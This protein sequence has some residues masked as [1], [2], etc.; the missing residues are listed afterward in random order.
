M[1]LAR[2]T[3]WQ[4][5]IGGKSTSRRGR[6]V[7]RRIALAG[8]LLMGLLGAL[9]P[10]APA[11]AS[12]AIWLH[13]QQATFMKVTNESVSM[14]T[15]RDHAYILWLEEDASHTYDW[16]YYTTNASGA[17]KTRLLSKA[18]PPGSVTDQYRA[19]IAVDPTLK[20]LYAVWPI[21][22]AHGGALDLYTSDDE[23]A[24]WKWKRHLDGR[25]DQAI[26]DEYHYPSVIQARDGA[27]HVTYSYFVKE[28]K[29]IKH[30]RF[31]EDWIKAGD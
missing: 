9:V 4:P 20:R 18:G 25:P 28:G 30:A 31:N 24:T 7:T 16:V 19:L 29:S 23:G 14:A 8:A 3:K 13:T 1:M 21:N 27:I 11:A 17:W 6:S 10:L 5:L 26:S 2:R 12:G 22:L 15:Y